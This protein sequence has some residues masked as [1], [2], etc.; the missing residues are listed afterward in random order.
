MLKLYVKL[1]MFKKRWPL[2][3]KAFFLF[4]LERSLQ[5][6][7]QSQRNST[8]KLIHY[9]LSSVKIWLVYLK[10]LRRSLLL[11]TDPRIFKKNLLAD[12]CE[13]IWTKFDR[14]PMK[15]EYLANI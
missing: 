8:F 4:D 9:G 2:L 14:V 15:N 7:G 11:L 3:K 12:V 13:K 6:Q 5:S 1:K 10:P